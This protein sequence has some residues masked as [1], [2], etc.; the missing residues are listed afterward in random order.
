M[1]RM[2]RNEE[3][4]SPP[5]RYS[6]GGSL[7]S[8]CSR[9]HVDET[10]AQYFF[11]QIIDAIAHCHKQGIVYRDVKPDNTLLSDKH[12]GPLPIIQ[13]R[14]G[15]N[16]IAHH[17]LSGFPGFRCATLACRAEWRTSPP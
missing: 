4:T 14:R 13:A 1:K 10:M 15:L 3:P 17:P 7:Q 2:R 16:N 6:T 11:L 8:F 12:H 9:S 5:R